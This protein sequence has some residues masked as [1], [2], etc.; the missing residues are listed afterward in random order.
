MLTIFD[1][2]W[3]IDLELYIGEQEETHLDAYGRRV[4][5]KTLLPVESDAPDKIDMKGTF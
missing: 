4:N 2:D 1:D 5:S 3:D